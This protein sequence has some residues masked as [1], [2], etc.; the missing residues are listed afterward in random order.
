[1]AASG[2]GA[3]LAFGTAL[4]K[5]SMNIRACLAFGLGLVCLAGGRLFAEGPSGSSP[6]GALASPVARLDLGHHSYKVTTASPNAQKAFDRGLTLTY[7]FGYEAAQREYRAALA[8][9][10]DCAMAWW[11][12]ALVNG[13]HINFPLVPPARAEA[14][15]QALT[16]AQ[17]LAARASPVERDL[18]AAL[19][20]RYAFPQPEDRSGLDRAYAEAMRGVWQKHPRDADVGTLFAESLMDLHPWDLWQ[21]DGTPQPWT[22]EIVALLETLLELNPRHPGANHYYIHAVEASVNPGRGLAAAARLGRL[23]PGSSHLVHMPSH[24]YARVGRWTD[25]AEANSRAM[26]ADAIYQAAYPRPGFYG[27][28]MAHNAHFYTFT[29]MMQG[30]SEEAIRYARRMVEG[31]PEEFRRD[32]AP[33]AD[34]FMILTSEVLVR[35]GRWKEV[36]AEPEPAADLPLS[37]ALWRFTRAAASSALGRTPQAL[38]EQAAFHEARALVPAGYTFGNNTASNLLK[39]AGHVL[40][41]EM[42]A[43]AGRYD[44]AV[45]EL[46]AAAQV[47]DRLVYDEPPDWLQPVRHSLGAVLLRAGRPGEAETVYREDLARWPENGWSLFGLGRALT[48]QGKGAE[49]KRLEDRFAKAWSR[50]DTRLDSSCLCLPG[51]KP[52]AGR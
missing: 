16:N 35:F 49:A 42:A 10:P 45:A 19:S 33:L 51:D 13:P 22:G 20:H 34:G 32:Y 25:A 47:E 30:R 52:L 8:A 26:E 41:G 1:M 21:W 36:L 2:F 9:D 29:A 17:G 40:A 11:G 43:Q 15:W 37:R 39:I 7:G 5:G 31:M 4:K 46:R 6:A 23:V 27:L 24:I 3:G 14:A 44:E 18:I 12:I 48:L 38:A 50:A 28:Y